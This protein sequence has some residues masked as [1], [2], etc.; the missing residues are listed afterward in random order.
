MDDRAPANLF[1]LAL[2]HFGALRG[3]Y[4]DRRLSAGVPLLGF[5][6]EQGAVNEPAGNRVGNFHNRFSVLRQA[7]IAA[8][9]LRSPRPQTWR[10]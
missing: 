6:F 10:A 9:R 5:P 1:R 7:W 8:F 4:G 2:D 3:L